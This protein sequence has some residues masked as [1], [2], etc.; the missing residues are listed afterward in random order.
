MKKYGKLISI[1][2]VVLSIGLIGSAFGFFNYSR[3]GHNNKV[4][5]GSLYLTLNEG[6]DSI[7]LSDVLPE[8]PESARSRNDNI[9]TFTVKG[10][11]TSTTAYTK[12]T[13]TK[14]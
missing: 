7:S 6:V 11:N 13:C 10:K 4:I 9:L 8:T 3:S 1:I 2:L 12:V 14:N 5:A